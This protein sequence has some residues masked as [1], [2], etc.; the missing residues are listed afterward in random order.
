MTVPLREGPPSSNVPGARAQRDTVIESVQLYPVPKAE[1]S[2]VYKTSNSE[3]Q[4]AACRCEQDSQR[5]TG[6]SEI[7]GSHATPCECCWSFGAAD[8]SELICCD[9]GKA[10]S[11]QRG[12]EHAAT[13]ALAMVS[14]PVALIAAASCCFEHGAPMRSA[15]DGRRARPLRRFRVLAA[16]DCFRDFADVELIRLPEMGIEERDLVLAPGLCFL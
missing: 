7:S 10:R 16:L 15:R 9:D 5:H 12:R 11:W 4:I 6:L 13:R 2:P 14:R 3:T 8:S 1:L